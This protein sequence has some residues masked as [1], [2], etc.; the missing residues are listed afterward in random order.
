MKKKVVVGEQ[1]G[2]MLGAVVSASGGHF[3]IVGRSRTAAVRGIVV[4]HIGA[5]MFLSSRR[6]LRPSA[7]ARCR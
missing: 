1:H 4:R 6:S 5:M 7:P 3:T 2:A